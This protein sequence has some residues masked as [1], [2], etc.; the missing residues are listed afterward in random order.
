MKKYVETVT[1]V[2][3]NANP[4]SSQMRKANR[5]FMDRLMGDVLSG[6]EPAMQSKSS[7][8]TFPMWPLLLSTSSGHIADEC[9]GGDIHPWACPCRDEAAYLVA[10]IGGVNVTT[11]AS[12]D[13]ESRRET[14]SHS[15]NYAP[16]VT[17]GLHW[18]LL[19]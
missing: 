15:S 6:M 12:L 10:A 8:R 4:P 11:K 18:S 3:P 9:I 19:R 13:P 17:A 1:A 16:P 2:T 7:D 14:P 5:N